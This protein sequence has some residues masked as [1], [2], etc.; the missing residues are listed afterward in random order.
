MKTKTTDVAEVDVH[1]NPL[2]NQ[3][4]LEN[5][6]WWSYGWWS[7]GK[8]ILTTEDFTCWHVRAAGPSVIL[9]TVK[10]FEKGQRLIERLAATLETGENNVAG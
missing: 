3:W 2:P 7:S 10:T 8:W 9:A 4:M 1:G 5:V 6:N